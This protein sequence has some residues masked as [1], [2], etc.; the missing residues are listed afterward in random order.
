MA[1]QSIDEIYAEYKR[2]K[3]LSL[4]QKIPTS[5]IAKVK[6]V[7]PF[8]KIL[9]QILTLINDEKIEWL[10]KETAEPQRGK[11]IIFANTHR[12]KPDFE[13]ITIKTKDLDGKERKEQGRDDAL[14]FLFS[15]G[16]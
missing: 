5:R 10:R 2:E 8:T 12:F 4:T 14:L 15:I 11:T 16:F 7:Y 9:L 6:R 13:K 1:K 3:E